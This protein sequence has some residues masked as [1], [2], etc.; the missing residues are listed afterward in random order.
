[1]GTGFPPARSDGKALPRFD[2]SAGEAKSHKIMR[3]K[4]QQ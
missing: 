3:Q 2:A 4:M 1:M